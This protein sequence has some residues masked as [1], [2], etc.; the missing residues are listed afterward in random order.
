MMFPT[1][2]DAFAK[3]A[4]AMPNNCMFLVDTYNTIK[5]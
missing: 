4:A 1:E 3:Y 2:E 5:V